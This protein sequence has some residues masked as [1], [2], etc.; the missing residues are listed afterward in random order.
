M[1][2]LASLGLEV[3]VTE[4]D[5]KVNVSATGEI[6]GNATAVLQQ[7]ADV[8]AGILRA[9]LNVPAC[10]SWGVWGFFGR[11]HKDLLDAD[12]GPKPA[13][14]AVVDELKKGRPTPRGEGVPGE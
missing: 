9:C 1:H 12:F 13:F 14:W 7:Q 2:K 6:Q 3:H 8:Y 11:Q 10:K 5:V 4:M